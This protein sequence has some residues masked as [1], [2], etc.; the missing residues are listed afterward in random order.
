MSARS[1]V[2]GESP[3]L[4][5]ACSPAK[6]VRWLQTAEGLESRLNGMLIDRYEANE[7]SGYPTL[8]T[9]RF[10]VEGE[11]CYAIEEPTSLNT[12]ELLPKLIEMGVWAVKIEERQRSSAYVEQVTRVWRK[13]IDH[14]LSDPQRF[15]IHPE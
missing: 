7:K 13:T 10:V 9:G 6:A 4:N 3:N 15:S 11:A 12:L 1:Y 5:G 14:C 8:C 2:T